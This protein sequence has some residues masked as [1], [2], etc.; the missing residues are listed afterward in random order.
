MK[1]SEKLVQWILIQLATNF[2][3]F[4]C[5][6]IFCL[7]PNTQT[8]F[9]IDPLYP[10]IYLGILEM[11][12]T[13]LSPSPMYWQPGFAQIFDHTLNI[14]QCLIKVFISTLQR[15]KLSYTARH[16]KVY[17]TLT[18]LIDNQS[19]K[20]LDFVLLMSILQGI[21][22]QIPFPSLTLNWGSVLRRLKRCFSLWI[23]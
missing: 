6:A 8:W 23:L 10:P 7:F 14:N 3:F 16:F 2:V 17:I 5:L 19:V 13:A 9:F 12:L 20:L 11:C 4:I 15:L 21:K 1:I 22:W 18:F